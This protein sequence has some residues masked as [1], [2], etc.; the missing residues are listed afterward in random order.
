MPGQR[1]EDGL[2]GRELRKVMCWIGAIESLDIGT[3]VEAY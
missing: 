2:S 3:L 1:S